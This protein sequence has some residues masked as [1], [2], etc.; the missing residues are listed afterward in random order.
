M[1]ANCQFSSSRNLGLEWMSC[2][3]TIL[4]LANIFLNKVYPLLIYKKKSCMDKSEFSCKSRMLCFSN[5]S[6]KHAIGS[7]KRLWHPQ[8]DPKRTNLMWGSARDYQF[9]P[10]TNNFIGV[11]TSFINLPVLQYFIYQFTFFTI[12]LSR[13]F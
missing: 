11:G 10:E 4:V 8:I 9:H 12:P 7:L 2:C 6:Q 5:F 3:G 13:V 1:E